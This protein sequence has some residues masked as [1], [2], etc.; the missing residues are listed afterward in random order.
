MAWLAL[1]IIEAFEAV[2]R[3]ITRINLYGNPQ[4]VL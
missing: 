3:D 2:V 4:K 1:S